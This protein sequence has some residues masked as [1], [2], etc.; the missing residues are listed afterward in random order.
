MRDV[1]NPGTDAPP[2]SE[3]PDG[4]PRQA[5]LCV[6]DSPL[7]EYAV[8][9]FD[10]GYSLADP[11]MLVCWEAQFGD[12]C[13]GAQIAI[14]QYIAS[15]EVKWDRWSGL[16]LL[17]PHG[18]EP[19]GPEHPSARLERFLQLCGDHNMQVVYPTTA[20]QIFHLLRRQVR[21]GFRKPLIVMTPKGT[22]RTPTGTIDELTTGTFREVLDDPAFTRPGAE[23]KGV[24]RIIL[25][26]GKIYFELA[27]RREKLARTD[28]AIIRIEQLY[29]FHADMLQRI[30]AAYPK[31]AEI[32]YVQ[33]EP[34]NAGAYLF[35]A[36]QVRQ[37]LKLELPYIGRDASASPAVGSKSVSKGQQEA[38]LTRAVG[39][40]PDAKS[41]RNAS[42]SAAKVGT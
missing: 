20:P 2:L 14:D 10:Y 23:R 38:V 28:L 27:E 30:L 5:R 8:M 7:S 4:K 31:S 41:A 34:R 16:V 15:A 32:V 19:A 40:L 21:R 17:L 29:P 1:G 35:V 25:C 33:E 36:D 39:P 42:K 11:N 24:K 22:L 3:G 37:A 12:F 13:N 18:Y 26:S 9:G 6:Y